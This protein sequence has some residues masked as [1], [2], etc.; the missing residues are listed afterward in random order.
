[1]LGLPITHQAL[2]QTFYTRDLIFIVTPLLTVSVSM[3][4][5]RGIKREK[6]VGDLPLSLIRVAA[7]CSNDS[8]NLTTA[9]PHQWSSLSPP[10]CATFPATALESEAAA[11]AYPGE[12]CSDRRGNLERERRA[13]GFLCPVAGASLPGMGG[14][15][16]CLG[17]LVIS[18]FLAVGDVPL[19]HPCTRGTSRRP[20]TAVSKDTCYPPRPF[21]FMSARWD[22]SGCK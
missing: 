14:A 7:L 18:R 6:R 22:T 1:M 13:L 15:V 4:A 11:S 2:C 19:R 21:F 3:I 17:R 5:L 8:M 16:W 10:S 9:S 20:V 12:L